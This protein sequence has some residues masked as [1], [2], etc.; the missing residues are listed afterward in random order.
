[1]PP[2][3]IGL[4]SSFVHLHGVGPASERRLWERGLRTWEDLLAVE[5][6]ERADALRESITRF[7]SNDWN[8]FERALPASEKWRAFADLGDRA[9][10]V[11]I[12]TDGGTDEDCITVIGCFD[13]VTAHTFV[14]GRDLDRAKDLIEDHPLVVT[15][16]GAQFDMPLIRRRFTY[17][18]FNHVH[19]DLR[20]PLR[21]LGLRGGLKSIERQLGLARSAETE[22]LGGW[23]AVRL[24]REWEQGREA[25]LEILLAYNREDTRN[26]RPLMQHAFL[27]LSRRLAAPAAASSTDRMEE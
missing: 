6:G 4:R 7:G 15:F 18:L 20:F 25:S 26:M 13:G 23:D 27:E 5:E 14:R 1:M 17:N 2:P 24:W 21:R 22:G 19:I 12:E 3:A 11:D 8:W 9:L 10:Y 16:N